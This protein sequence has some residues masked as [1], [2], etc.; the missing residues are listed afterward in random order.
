MPAVFHTDRLLVRPWT[1]DD[2]DRHYDTYSRMDVA[3]WLGSVP[4]PLTDPAQSPG[5]IERWAARG[6]P[7]GRYG[8]WAVERKDDGVV[9]GTVLLVP[10]P[11]TGQEQAAPAEQGGDVEVGWH[12][13]PDSWGR[14]LATEAARGAIEKGFADGLREIVAVVHAPNEA[15][16]KVCRRLGMTPTGPTDK[17]YGVELESF[18]I[19]RPHDVAAARSQRQPPVSGR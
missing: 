15:S 19:H 17:W 5:V 12:F 18:V 7:D 8:I 3:R 10:I 1:L 4:Q 9:A 14:G 2:A 13:H 6:G 11:L 16:L